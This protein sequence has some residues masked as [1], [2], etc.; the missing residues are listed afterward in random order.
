MNILVVKANNRPTAE[1]ESNKMY[2]ALMNGLDNAANTQITTYDV[3]QEDMPYIG[4]EQFDAMKKLQ[5]GEELNETELRLMNAKQ[6]AKD[7]FAAADIVIFTFPMWNLTIP[8][9]LHTFI[10]YIDEVGFTF[11]FTPEGVPLHPMK[12]KKIILLN[13]RGGNFSEGPMQPLEHAVTYME[14]IFNGM[15]GM[16]II[17]KVVIEGHDLNP[18]ETDNIISEGLQKVN[19]I[20]LSLVK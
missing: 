15:F 8:A 1:S 2:E 7:L 5:I 18:L 11:S 9:R 4:Q 13:A 10:D 3:F 12:N 16:E 19:Q 17:N 6:K 20:A 14:H